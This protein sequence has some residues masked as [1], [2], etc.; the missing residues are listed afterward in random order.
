[1]D[2]SIQDLFKKAYR[3]LY[4][5]SFDE[6]KELEEEQFYNSWVTSLQNSENVVK[7]SDLKKLEFNIESPSFGKGFREREGVLGSGEHLINEKNYEIEFESLGEEKY[8]KK[9]NIKKKKLFIKEKDSKLREIC[10]NTDF[11]RFEKKHKKKNS[12][13]IKL[14][15]KKVR[16][17]KSFEKNTRFLDFEI[18]NLFKKKF[19]GSFKKKNDF[20]SLKNKKRDFSN[21][22]QIISER[23]SSLKNLKKKKKKNAL[24]KNFSGLNKSQETDNKRYHFK[25]PSFIHKKEIFDFKEHSRFTF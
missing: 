13:N 9:K 2:E 14:K 10:L 22:G 7:N 23:K 8:L 24:K 16:N 17:P 19:K 5:G 25:K 1:M 15:K 6:I 3:K 4:K 18:K 12:L 11:K 21:Y 20:S